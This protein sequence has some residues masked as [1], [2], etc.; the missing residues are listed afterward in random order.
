MLQVRSNRTGS[1]PVSDEQ[2]QDLSLVQPEFVLV[3]RQF[4]DGTGVSPV[5]R[6]PVSPRL[7]HTGENRRTDGEGRLSAPGP[8]AF[9][10]GGAELQGRRWL[11][12]AG[13]ACSPAKRGGAYPGLIQQV[14]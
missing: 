6:C 1:D 8:P 14:P 2:N 12:T 4:K 7:R 5:P 3:S 10:S 9:C 13:A 11:I